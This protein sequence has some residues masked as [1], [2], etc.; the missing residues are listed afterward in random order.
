MAD[1]RRDRLAGRVPAPRRWFRAPGRV[2]L[3]GDHTDYHDG[4]V[5]PM[6]VDRD[7]LVVRADTDE[8]LRGTTLDADEALLAPWMAAL[9]SVLVDRG[10]PE[11][12]GVVAVASNV[13]MGAGLASSGA[14]AVALT[15]AFGAGTPG[16]PVA[17][18]RFARE[19][20]IRATGV[21]GGLMDQLASAAGVAGHA[22]FIDCAVMRIEPVPLPADLGV[23]VVH[24]G[25]PRVL[26]TSEYAE[27]RAASTAVA[28]RLGL[29]TLREAT[30]V[31]VRSDPLARHVVSEN[32]RV[33]AAVDALAAG[34]GPR[35]GELMAAS[36]ASL[37]DDYAVST[38]ELDRLVDLL[39]AEG[40]FGARLTGAGFGGCVV[41]VAPGGGAADIARRAAGRY[42]DETGHDPDV[43][44][45]RAADGAGEITEPE[46]R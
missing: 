24:S 19:V 3:I 10:R 16:D 22:L 34:D 46:G 18:A 36:H 28:T 5:L 23:V 12:T 1:D 26:A 2:N 20:E 11:P 15:T 7:C 39:T 33:M 17:L 40:A 27:R 29:G 13:P 8:P 14:L 32:A 30:S 31:Q 37:R 42:A 41:G 45:P 21:V 4:L 25:L 44:L 43:L 9:R 6:A 38:P 35:L